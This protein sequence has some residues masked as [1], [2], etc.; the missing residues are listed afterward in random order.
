[1]TAVVDPGRTRRALF[2]RVEELPD[3][4]HL[5]TG[6]SA[7]HVVREKSCDC[8]DGIY[9]GGP[10]KHRVAV[11]FHRQLDG[12]VREALRAATEGER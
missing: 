7:P 10:C 9:F 3:G 5:V 6:G 8:T 4:A 1:M 11:Y 2:L 12:R